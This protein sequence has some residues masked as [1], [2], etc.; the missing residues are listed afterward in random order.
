MVAYALGC[1][2]IIGALWLLAMA[3]GWGL[4]YL[5]SVQGLEWFKANPW[6]SAFVAGILLLL[7]LLLF[8]R[9]R[10]G[11]DRAFLTSSKGGEV[12]ISQ[13]ALQEIIARSAMVL[14]GVRQVQSSLRERETGLQIMVSCQFEQGVLI[15]QMSEELQAKVKQD[16][17]LYTGI[18]V[19]EVKVLVR[20][21]EKARSARV[22]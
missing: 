4:P 6:E 21:L 7:G 9:P 2:L 13:D 10:E 16:V 15:P 14:T 11:T 5:L 22:R 12:R 17:E 3:T 20:S 8:V 19:T 18:L 1:L